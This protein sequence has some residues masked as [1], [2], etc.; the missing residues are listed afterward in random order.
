VSDDA[1]LEGRRVLVVGASSGIGRALA[2]AAGAR[3]AKVA[4]AARRV[5]LVEDVAA[6]I[7]RSGSEAKAWPCD[8]TDEAQCARVVDDAAAWL[9][10][11]DL[12]VYMSG[13][14]PLVRI[15]DATAST[16]HALLST[17]L[18]G[19]ALVVGRAL[20][21]LRRAERPAVVVT[22]HSMGRPWPWLGVYGATKAGLAELARGLRS[23]EPAVRVL[24][25]AVGQ[26]ATSFA[27]N[28]DEKA[29][30]AAF[31][32]WLSAGVLRYRTLQAS[33]M[34]EGILAAVA[35]E[36]GPDDLLIAGEEG[37]DDLLVVDTG[38]S[39]DRS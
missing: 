8:V 21:H 14:S 35:D 23:E 2:V 37:R 38:A 5:E 1:R 13:T 20:E 10:G 7:R 30:T 28:W 11:I 12:L 22:T 3:G 26:T 19:A 16:W 18:V 29:A 27:D 6:E 32:R 15:E 17:N 36:D 31:E 4:L 9:G 39:S 24:C 33:E 25:V 34:A